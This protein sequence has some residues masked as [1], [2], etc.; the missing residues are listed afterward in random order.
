MVAIADSYNSNNRQGAESCSNGTV[1]FRQTYTSK[2]EDAEVIPENSKG[3]LR[4]LIKIKTQ[5]GGYLQLRCSRMP[6]R[7]TLSQQ[8][9]AKM[10][11]GPRSGA[12]NIFT[13]TRR[14][15]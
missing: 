12:L 2:V 4:G 15:R 7:K 14:G 3:K 13:P 10:K 8:P 1:G 5:R 11:K 6:L 9:S